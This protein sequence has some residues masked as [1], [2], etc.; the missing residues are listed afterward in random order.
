L[1]DLSTRK[2]IPIPGSIQPASHDDLK[3]VLAIA[4]E[5]GHRLYLVGGYLRDALLVAFGKMTSSDKPV[6]DFDFAVE[7]GHGFVFAKYV[8]DKMNGHFV[9]LDEAN[10]TARVVLDNGNTLDF[11][12]CVGGTIEA[13]VWR[14]DFTINSL[15]WDPLDAEQITDY[16]GSLSDLE[17]L[18]IRAVSESVF[19]EDPLRILRAYRFAAAI[20][21]N[22]ETH[23]RQW[24]ENHVARL[25]KTAVERINFELFAI[26]NHQNSGRFIF[27]MG[28]AGLLE[29][30]F[31][32][33]TE[34]RRVTANAFHHLA[35]FEHSLETIPQLESRMAQLPDFVLESASGE[36]SFGVSRLAATKVAA[37]LHDIGK[38]ETWVIN[39]DGRHTF[40]GHDRIGAD[41]CELVA[42]RLK[43]SKPVSK[44]IV[45]LIAWHLRPGQLFHQGLPTERA[46]RRFY[47]T[48]GVDTPEL[49]MLAFAD[50]G[51]TCGPGLMG[52]NRDYLDNSLIDLMNGYKDFENAA[53]L[54]PKLLDGNQIMALL[55][56]SGGPVIGTLLAD[57]DEA[58]GFNEVLDRAS[59]ELF[60]KKLYLEKYSK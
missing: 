31:P 55:G 40:Y 41:L 9:P 45:K 35:L 32:E 49:M 16:V 11:A 54:Q 60:I 27:D 18:T 56:I 53:K 12:G 48:C 24:L 3:R 17:N 39:D 15:V 33:L 28:A 46:I 37:L 51:A 8:A 34:C 6:K 23:T 21:G 44:F 50:L 58:Q 30:I 10:D 26:F 22:I 13:D 4:D 47:R 52:E 42:E 19:I 2:Q 5:T 38:P 25:A 36:L 1:S 7:G 57:L 29:A 14:R 43:W 59:A 20:D